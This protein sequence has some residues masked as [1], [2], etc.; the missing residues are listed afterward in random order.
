MVTRLICCCCSV[1]KLYPTLCDYLDCNMLG[2]PV[3][4]YLLEF[5]QIHVHW[6]GDAIQ[7]SPPQSPPSPPALN[8]PQHQSLFQ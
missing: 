1:T 4:Y 3:L 8:F 7:P 6:V 5:A 2:F